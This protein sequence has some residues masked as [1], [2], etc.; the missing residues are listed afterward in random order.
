MIYNPNEHLPF[1][2]EG[3][4]LLSHSCHHTVCVQG[5]V[6]LSVNMNSQ[7]LEGFFPRASRTHILCTYQHFI[8]KAKYNLSYPL[9]IG[10]AQHQGFTR[11]SGVLLGSCLRE[12]CKGYLGVF[13]SRLAL[14]S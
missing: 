1:L 4:A 8:F 5:L 7:L 6:R 2:G 10:T 13:S 14:V 3:P 9:F 11:S 12:L